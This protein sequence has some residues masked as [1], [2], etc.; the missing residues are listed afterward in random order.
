MENLLSFAA[1]TALGTF[2]YIYALPVYN[3]ISET[4]E[5]LPF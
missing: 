2:L 1:A 4:L 5:S 3:A